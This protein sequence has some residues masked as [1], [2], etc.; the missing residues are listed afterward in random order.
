MR[1][2]SEGTKA[3][4]YRFLAKKYKWSFRTISCMTPYQQAIAV[5]D[6][7]ED[8]DSGHVQYFDSLDDALDA[9]GDIINE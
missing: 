3:D 1:D 5:G 4:V 8:D 6:L 9:L 7:L 2:G